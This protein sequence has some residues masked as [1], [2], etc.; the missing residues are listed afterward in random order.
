[1][2]VPYFFNDSIKR[3]LKKWKIKWQFTAFTCVRFLI[4]KLMI[5]DR[6]QD[7]QSSRIVWLIYEF[8]STV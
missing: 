4:I 2:I 7:E 1:M 6:F 5:V 3:L 8:S